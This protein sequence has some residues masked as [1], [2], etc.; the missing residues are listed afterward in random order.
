MGEGAGQRLDP[1]G[2]V[3]FGAEAKTAATAGEITTWGTIAE[4]AARGTITK[5]AATIEAA[6]TE[7]TATAA[8]IT[9]WGTIPEITARGAIPKAT[10]AAEFT[11]RRTR[12][13]TAFALLQLHD[14]RDQ[15][16]A[17][18]VRTHFADQLVTGIWRFNA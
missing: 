10:T 12:F 9:A 14:P 3:I 17:L 2:I 13:A 16:P 7:A 4:I 15:A 1:A 5:A 18:P 11:T 6:T 8:E